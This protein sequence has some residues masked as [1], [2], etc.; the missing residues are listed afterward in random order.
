[1]G[2]LVGQV[3]NLTVDIRSGWKLDLPATPPTLKDR[4]ACEPPAMRPGVRHYRPK[5]AAVA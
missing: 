1:V 4:E 2:L 5:T 3:S